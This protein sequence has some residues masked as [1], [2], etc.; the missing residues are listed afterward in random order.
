MGTLFKNSGDVGTMQNS[1]EAKQR[2][3]DSQRKL[4]DVMSLYL[5]TKIAPK[6]KREKLILYKRVIQQFHVVEIQNAHQMANFWHSVMREP[7]VKNAM[8]EE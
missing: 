4:L 1:L 3:F 2:D 5:G 7:I 8:R 6:F